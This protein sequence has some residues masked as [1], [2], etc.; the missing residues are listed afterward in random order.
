MYVAAALQ[1]FGRIGRNIFRKSLVPV[2][3][4]LTASHVLAA[5]RPNVYSSC[6]RKDLFSSG[7]AQCA[8]ERS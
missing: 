5:E 6:C 4:V 3:E 1:P 7:G 2:S 8:S